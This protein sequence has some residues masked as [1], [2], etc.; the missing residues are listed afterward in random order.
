LFDSEIELPVRVQDHE[1]SGTAP[2]KCTRQFTLHRG[3]LAY[4]PRGMYHSARAASDSSLHLTL[5]VLSKTWCELIIEAISELSLHDVE[6]QRALS[7]G[8]GTLSFDLSSSKDR[9]R[10]LLEHAAA[11]A[12]FESAVNSLRQ[13]FIRTRDPNLREQFANMARLDALLPKRWSRRE[14]TR[15]IRS[16]RAAMRSFCTT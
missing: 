16:Y 12:D 13:D 15:F 8:F 9:F 1:Q 10:R 14:R 4:I 11:S 3:D 5:G 7:V 2:G 6:M